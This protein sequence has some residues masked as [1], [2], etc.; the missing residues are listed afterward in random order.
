METVGSLRKK[1]FIK[2]RKENKLKKSNILN[3][4]HIFYELNLVA[5]HI[6]NSCLALISQVSHVPASLLAFGM[7]REVDLFPWGFAETQL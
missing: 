1:T 5:I 7:C 3:R 2:P 4:R 6:M